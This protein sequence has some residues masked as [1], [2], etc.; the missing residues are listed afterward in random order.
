MKE[1][2]REE[3]ANRE[4]PRRRTRLCQ[5]SSVLAQTLAQALSGPV[6]PAQSVKPE[7]VI[8]RQ[9]AMSGRHAQVSNT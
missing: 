6:T 9:T 3:T 2:D 7:I 4:V 8:E 1:R 5:P